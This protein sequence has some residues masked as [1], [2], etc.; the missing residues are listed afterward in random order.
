[1]RSKRLTSPVSHAPFLTDAR[2]SLKG[3]ITSLHGGFSKPGLSK[4]LRLGQS[5][6]E[7]LSGLGLASSVSA[8]Q[9]LA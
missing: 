3:R 1:M 8:N 7:K 6:S 9:F 4:M 2:F 5:C